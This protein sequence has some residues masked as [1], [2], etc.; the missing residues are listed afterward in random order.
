MLYQKIDIK[1]LEV[2]PKND[3]HGE[4]DSEADAI[5]W[6]LVN[7]TEKM[8]GLLED[9]S[10]RGGIID[11]PLVMRKDGSDNYTVYDGNR[12]VTC[13][14]LLKNL[15]P[16]IEDH[17]LQ[18]FLASLKKKNSISIENHI[19][20][21]VENDIDS[22]NDILELR[23]TSKNSG[24]GQLKWDA[25]EKE[26]FLDRTGKSKKINFARKINTLLI[27]KGY[28]EENERIPLSNFNR[29]FSSKAI[30][31]R[32][33]IEIHDHEIQIIKNEASV[34]KALAHIAKDFISSDKTLDD[35]WDNQK[36][37][38]YFDE[39]EAE[40]ILPSLITNPQT[41]ETAQK[42]DESKPIPKKPLSR[43]AR[44]SLLPSTLPLPKEN[45]FFSDKFCRLFNE[46]QNELKFDKH[47]ISISISFRAFLEIL[48]NAYID[49]HQIPVEK[50]I[51]LAGKIKTA[52]DFMEKKSSMAQKTTKAFIDKLG[53]DKKLFSINT[54]HKSQ[55]SDYFMSEDDLCAY[56]NNLDYYL[57]Q[58]IVAINEMS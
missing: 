24:A 42:E 48:T 29:L 50:K 47:L 46:L 43:V 56:I 53:D 23:H 34:Y 25:H 58:A 35:I 54:L 37:N 16:H 27:Q 19:I 17:P 32:V 4:L 7:K 41:S 52:F 15:A 36:K 21:R 13:L 38:L 55:H 3:R 6:L 44:K 40:G 2:N 20:C 9:I 28:L 14:K 49:A 10:D 39:L 57:R 22:I 26:N 12:R 8:K 31:R 1:D 33:G 18:S 30:I 5:K 51:T 11:S 45:T